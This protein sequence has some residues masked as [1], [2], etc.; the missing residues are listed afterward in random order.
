[1]R[2]VRSIENFNE[3][4]VCITDVIIEVCTTSNKNASRMECPT[5]IAMYM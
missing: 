4:T 5:N 1:M 3:K 2:L